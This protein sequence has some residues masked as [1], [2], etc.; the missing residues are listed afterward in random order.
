MRA[1]LLEATPSQSMCTL[2]RTRPVPNSLLCSFTIP[3][4]GATGY[5]PGWSGRG[6]PRPI[7][8]QSSSILNRFIGGYKR[9]GAKGRISYASAA[10]ARFELV[11]GSLDM[12]NYATR[13][14]DAPA[15]IRHDFA[16]SNIFRAKRESQVSRRTPGALT[17]SRFAGYQPRAGRK[18]DSAT[19]ARADPESGAGTKL[20]AQSPGAVS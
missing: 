9:R 20:P 10:G 5:E 16:R 7:S 15:Q 4:H 13:Y 17:G 14:R 18:I 8:G 12:G 19:H 6:A 1:Y 3:M 11:A 2:L